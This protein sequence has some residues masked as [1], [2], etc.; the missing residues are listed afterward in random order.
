MSPLRGS[1]QQQTQR[2]QHQILAGRVG[3][4]PEAGLA[5]QPLGEEEITTDQLNQVVDVQAQIARSGIGM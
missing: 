5:G 1:S 3:R 4:L 2:R